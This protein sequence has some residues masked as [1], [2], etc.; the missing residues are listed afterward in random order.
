MITYK[1]ETRELQVADK[2]FCDRC[3]KEV[4]DEMEIQEMYR[5]RFIGGWASVFG[6]ENSISCDLC[7]QCLKELI[8]DFCI[9]NAEE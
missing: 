3:K 5:I 2:I 7:Q 4:K 9:Y 8:G 1:T 6:D